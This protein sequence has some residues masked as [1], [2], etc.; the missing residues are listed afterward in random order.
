MKRKCLAAVVLAGVLCAGASFPSLADTKV[1]A[2]YLSLVGDEDLSQMTPGEY[3][4]DLSP[5]AAEGYYYISDYEVNENSSSGL[6]TY[7]I[8]V[9]AVDGA[10]FGSDTMV[11]VYGACSVSAVVRSSTLIRV[12]A[13]AYPLRVLDE[14]SD[15]SIDPIGKKATWSPV[16]GAASYRVVIQYYSDGGNVRSIKTTVKKTE[17]NLSAYLDKYDFVEVAVRPEKGNSTKDRYILEP[18]TYTTSDG[19]V[20]EEDYRGSYE[21]NL[22]TSVYGKLAD[23]SEG[24]NPFDPSAWSSGY[25]GSGGGSVS[26]GSSGTASGSVSGGSGWVGGG[27]TW[28]YETNGV[29]AT[30]W[31]PLAPEEWYYFDGSGL[32]KAG[33][34][35]DGSSV[36]LLNPS[37]DGTY[38]KMLAGYQLY[39]GN[40]YYFNE[41]HDGFFGAM[42]RNSATPDG[43]WAD[44]NGVVR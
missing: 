33:W 15:I 12:N 19:G 35:N 31:L 14:V 18:D 16:D 30:G 1:D 3:R 32:M 34:I 13:K 6:I 29:R 36:Y 25:P 24:Y 41:L 11:S 39:N 7:I 42:Y 28:Y 22:P 9:N 38:G 21:F 4:T 17:I 10:Y 23:G 2:V 43:R 8:E 26:G 27:D 20:Y 5:A 44:E 37:H 40:V